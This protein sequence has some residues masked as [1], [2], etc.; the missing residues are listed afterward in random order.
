MCEDPSLRPVAQ[1]HPDRPCPPHWSWDEAALAQSRARNPGAHPYAFSHLP[2]SAHVIPS[3]VMSGSPSSVLCAWFSA[4]LKHFILCKACPY[5]SLG[6][7]ATLSYCFERPGGHFLNLFYKAC[8][9]FQFLIKVPVSPTNL[10][11]SWKKRP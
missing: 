8:V 2:A 1:G 6:C 7:P 9:I 10:L 11:V 5:P 4:Q 3:S